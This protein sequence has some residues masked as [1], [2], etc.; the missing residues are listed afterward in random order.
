M[1]TSTA[2]TSCSLGIE[3]NI[4]LQQIGHFYTV[5]NSK[6][7]KFKELIKVYEKTYTILAVC[8]ALSGSDVP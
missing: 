4:S 5:V 2:D 3:L 6:T 8:R 1:L 7:K